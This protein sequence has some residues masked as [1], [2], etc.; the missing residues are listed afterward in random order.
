MSEKAFRLSIISSCFRGDAYLSS[1]IDQLMSQTLFPGLEWVLIHNEPSPR[2]MEIVKGFQERFPEKI[3]HFVIHPVEPLSAS[4]NRGWKC[5]SAE[6]VS[7]WNLDDC[8]PKDSL[9]RQIETLE[10]NPDCV[11]TYGDYLEV[12]QYGSSSGIWR[13]TPPAYTILLRRVFPGGAFMVWRKN[14]AERLGY[15]D[16]QLNIACDY[17]LVTR[18]AVSGMKLCK[19]SGFVGYFT[20]E[21]VGLSTIKGT[22]KET[23]ERTVV[24]LRYAIFDKVIPENTLDAKNYRISEILIEGHWFSLAV[25]VKNYLSY[26]RRRMFLQNLSGLRKF[27]MSILGIKR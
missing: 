15:F 3:K 1:F 14:A 12:K 20:N 25:F 27:F 19:T 26:V 4:W 11:M 17:D 13:K 6:Y 8:R 22:N 18:A 5:A 21:G 7:F 24:Q 10:R 9:Q 2:E 16:E 23:V